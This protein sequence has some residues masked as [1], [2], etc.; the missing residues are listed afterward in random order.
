MKKALILAYDFPPYISVGAL[1][2][3]SWFKYLQEFGIH[4]TVV[5]RQWDIKNKGFDYIL[6][7]KSKDLIIEKTKNEEILKTPYFPSFSNKL[8]YKYGPKKLKKTRKLFSGF[9][10]IMENLFTYGPKSSIYLYSRKYLKA[11]KVDIIIATGE[12]FILFKYASKLSTEY[13]IP[14]IADYRDA[15]IQDKTRR[16]NFLL[17]EFDKVMEKKYLKNVNT[18]ITVSEYLKNQISSF[19]SNKPFKILT[20]GFDP[21]ISKYA[22]ETQQNTNNLSIGFMGTIYPWHPIE[23]FLE[24]CNKASKDFKLNIELNF[25][26]INKEEEIKLIMKKKLMNRKLK[27]NF[28]QKALNHQV[29]KNIAINNLFLLFNDYHFLGTKIFDY[30]A[31]RRNIILCF[32]RENKEYKNDEFS[33]SSPNDLQKKMIRK[34]RSGV[35]IKDEVELLKVLYTFSNEL[36]EKGHISCNTVNANQ[37]S[38]YNTT[39][40]LASLLKTIV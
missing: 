29:A 34:T 30:L 14:W 36:K 25:Y 19:I 9:I 38:R 18:I 11:N 20:N 40:E 5:T 28:F 15:W 2:P 12:P 31:L 3:Y 35:T 32:D 37:Y 16:N 13:N 4:P 1:R 8:L 10:Y 6:P 26:G 22:N 33:I 21:I 23:S 39:K 27:I 24:T 7:S 17:K